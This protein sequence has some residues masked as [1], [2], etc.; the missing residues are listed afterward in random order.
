MGVDWTS[1]SALASE[2]GRFAIHAG[3][4]S[5]HEV[6]L[7]EKTPVEGNNYVQTPT[8]TSS[9]HVYP[10]STSTVVRVYIYD[11]TSI[12]LQALLEGSSTISNGMNVQIIYMTNKGCSS[13]VE[14]EKGCRFRL[15][16]KRKS[17]GRD[18]AETEISKPYR[19][20]VR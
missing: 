20:Q 19:V 17:K 6:T 3:S 4:A 8:S 1:S 10:A 13:R 2:V 18:R 14:E 11:T 16:N 15:V 7:V 9:V 12:E 5:P